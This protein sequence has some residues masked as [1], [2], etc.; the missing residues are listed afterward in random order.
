MNRGRNDD[1]PFNPRKHLPVKLIAATIT[2]VVLLLAGFFVVEVET[3]AGNQVG[4]MET[5]TG[6]VE[7]NTLA[8]R[9]YFLFP[10]Y[11]KEVFRYDMTPHVF[12]LTG[13]NAYSVKSS[14]NQKV[15]L[16]IQMQW[17]YDPGMIIDIHTHYRAHV[18][19]SDWEQIME[20]RLIGP[21]VMRE[22]N[23]EATARKAIDAYSGEGFVSLQNDISRRLA[24][25]SGEL[26]IQGILVENFVIAHVTL[27]EAYIG[28]I[29]KRQIAQQ[30]EL[31]A[32]AEERAALAE[33]QKAKAEAGADYEK[34]V[35]EARRD[36]EVGVLASEMEAQRQVNDATAAA[37]RVVL[38]AEAERKAG[39]ARGAAILALGKAEAEA[40]RLKLAAYSE[41]GSDQFVTVEVAKQ[42]ANAFQGVQGYLPEGMGINLLSS[43]FLD[44]VRSIVGR[45]GPTAATESK[46]DSV[47]VV[48]TTLLV[49][50][51]V[52][53]S[54]I[55]SHQSRAPVRRPQ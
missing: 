36:K 1:Q 16:E 3:V 26:R 31:R 22:I 47:S 25:P 14:D 2:L 30:A 27:D 52:G 32:Q 42:V 35:V 45:S 38:A 10:G 19:R 23:V 13:P 51:L 33:A 44:A 15:T 11:T 37:E 34:R 5:W 18:G 6:G 50:P 40:T 46:P 17:R 24:D 29:S 54:P 55:Q 28:E 20:Q 4:V 48:G 41:V 49:P 7:K 9:T 43:N 12:A 53:P 39:E 21:V 8:P